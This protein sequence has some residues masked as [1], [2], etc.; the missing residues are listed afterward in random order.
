MSCIVHQVNRY[1]YG[2]R[3]N[4]IVNVN[5]KVVWIVRHFVGVHGVDDGRDD[6]DGPD[7]DETE[8]GGCQIGDGSGLN[9]R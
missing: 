5:E 9:E 6:P 1:S 3:K 7:N 2:T 8:E 4:K